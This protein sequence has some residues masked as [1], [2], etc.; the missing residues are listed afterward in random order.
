MAAQYSQ[1]P[2]TLTRAGRT[3]ARVAHRG[4]LALASSSPRELIDT[5]LAAGRGWTGPFDATAST[6]EVDHANHPRNVDLAVVQQLDMA[7]GR[8]RPLVADSATGLRSAAAS[9]L[10]RSRPASRGPA[11]LRG[12]ER[13]RSHPGS[14]VELST[15]R[16]RRSS[17]SYGSPCARPDVCQRSLVSRQGACKRGKSRAKESYGERG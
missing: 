6:D 9:G 1:H 15:Q 12:L 16:S 5:V 8:A 14:L 4:R 17:N 13:R 10:R 2:A 7:P 11:I 3:L